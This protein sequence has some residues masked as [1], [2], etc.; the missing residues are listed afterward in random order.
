[1][2][3]GDRDVGDSDLALVAAADTDAIYWD[4][5]YHHHVVCLF[6]DALQHQVLANRFFYGQQLER[7]SAF[8][9]EARVLLLTDLAVKFLEIVL[10][11]ATHH[12]LPHLRLVPPLQTLEMD[13]AASP[14]AFA[15]GAEKLSRLFAFAQH[16]ILALQCLSFGYD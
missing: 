5:L 13:E 7:L 2:V 9:D 1:M 14:R 10:D 11:C 16:A 8:I 4:V 6:G 3:S 12:L 15:R